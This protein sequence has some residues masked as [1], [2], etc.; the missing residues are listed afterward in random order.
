MLFEVIQVITI[1]QAPGDS[2]KWRETKEIEMKDRQQNASQDRG[3]RQR[4]R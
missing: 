2:V 3:N 4:S 1:Y